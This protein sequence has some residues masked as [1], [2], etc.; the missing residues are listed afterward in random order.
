MRL[1]K[2]QNFALA[3]DVLVAKLFNYICGSGGFVELTV[4][5]KP[6]SPLGSRK[7]KLEAKE[8]LKTQGPEVGFVCVKDQNDE[9]IGVRVDLRKKICHQYA[10][11]GSCR[12]AQGKCKYWHICQSFI[13]GICDGKCGLSHDF[14]S[15]D[16][17]RMVKELGLEKYSNGT[18]RNIVAWSLPQVCQLYLRNECKS[19]KCPYLHVCLQVVQGSSCK[20]ILSHNLSDSHNIKILKQYDLVPPHQIIN[21]DFVR[22][23]ILVLNDQK[24]IETR[25]CLGGGRAVTQETAS[26]MVNGKQGAS[27]LGNTQTPAVP[28]KPVSK[29]EPPVTLSSVASSAKKRDNNDQKAKDLFECLCKEFNCSAPLAVLKN[30]KYVNDLQDASLFL[31][32]NSGKFLFTRNENGNIKDVTAFCPKLRLCFDFVFLSECKK[33]HCSSFHL[34]RKFV[35]GSCSRGEK[36]SR[37]HKFR[38]KRDQETVKKLDLDWLTNE[39]LRKLMLSSSPQVCISYNKDKCTNDS[40]CPRVHICKDFVVNACKNGDACRFQHK[41]AFDTHHTK[42]LLEKYRLGK[43]SHNSVLKTILVCEEDSGPK[44]PKPASI[45][46]LPAKNNTSKELTASRNMAS[47]QRRSMVQERRPSVSSSRSSEQAYEKL[48]PSK[49]AVFACISKEYNGS[50]PFAVISK[51]KDLFAEDSE[52]I[53]MWFRNKKE[54]FRLVEMADGTILEVNAFCRRAGFCYNYTSFT[55]CSRKDCEY[56]HVCREYIA[57]VCKFG[58]RCKWNHSFQFDRDRKFLCKL[59]LDDL[60]EEE[61]CKVIQLSTPQVCLN[62]NDGECKYDE[63][64]SLVHI[65]KD[66]LKKRCQDTKDCGLKHEEALLTPHTSAI[67]RNYGLNCTDGNLHFVLNTLLICKE[68]DNVL[69]PTTL[70][71]NVITAPAQDSPKQ[72]SPGQTKPS[73]PWNK[74]VSSLTSSA[75]V[76]TPCFPTE[77]KVFECLCKGYGSSASFSEIAEREDLFPHGSKSAEGWFRRT[78]GSFLMTE[79]DQGMISQVDAFSARARLCL[80]YNKNGKCDKHDCTY[81]H[82]CRDY[83]TDSCSS[84][85]TCPLNH[86]FHNERDKALLTR[87]KLDQFTDL[88]LRRL[89]LS[90]TPQICVEYNNDTCKRGKSCTKIHICCGYLRKCCSSQYECGLDHETAMDTD[91][92]QKVLE[93]LMLNN[94]SKQD[95]LEMILDDKHSLSGKDKTECHIHQDKPKASICSHFLIGKCNKGKRCLNH[96]CSMPYHWQYKVAIFDEW[97]SFSEK[98]N[99]TL[100]KLYCDVNAETRSK[101]K[102]A[103]SLDVSHLERQGSLPRDQKYE[104]DVDLDN[105]NITFQKPN[106]GGVSFLG[107]LRRLSTVAYVKNPCDYVFTNWKWYW[108]DNGKVWR[109]YDKDYS[110]RGLQELLE[111]A[112]LDMLDRGITRAR[113]K[114]TT[115]E[116]AYNLFFDSTREMYQVNLKFGTKRQVKRRP[117][118]HVS[119]ED[120]DDVKWDYGDCSVRREIEKRTANPC[121]PSHWSSMRPSAQYTRVRLDASSA[122]FKDVG[123]LFRKTMNDQAKIK[124]IERVQNP[125]MWEKYCRKK[126]NM[127]A[128][129]QRNQQQV[130]E[131]RLFHGTSPGTVEAICKQNFDWR[132]HGK[133]ATRFGEGS[134]FAVNASYS[135]AYATRNDV[136]LSQ[137]MFMAKVLVG[138]YTKGQPSYRR[139]PQKDPSNPASDLYDSCVDNQSNPTI[140]VVFDT[141]QFYPEYIIKYVF[142]TNDYSNSSP[143]PKPMPLPTPASSQ[144]HLPRRSSKLHATV[145]NPSRSAVKSG[146]SST[147]SG[148]GLTS[149]NQPRSS[150]NVGTGPNAGGSATGSSTVSQTTPA[151]HVLPPQPINAPLPKPGS[152]QTYPHGVLKHQTSTSNNLGKAS[153]PRASSAQSGYSASAASISGLTS[154]HP[155]RRSLGTASTPSGTTALRSSSN[156]GAGPNAGGSAA[157]SGSSTVSQTTSASHALSQPRTAPLPKPGSSQTYPHG[158]LQH[159]TSTSS[160]LGIASTPRATAAQSG[161]SASAASSSGWTSANPTTSSLGRASNPSVSVARSEYSSNVFRS[162]QSTYNTSGLYTRHDTPITSPYSST[163]SHGLH[164]AVTGTNKNHAK[165]KKKECVIS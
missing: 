135:H 92:T 44:V 119:N 144:T 30:R 139:P 122:E 78:K 137:F 87:I 101:F 79:N 130:N 72:S 28:E 85:V 141:D 89:V 10:V 46:S 75:T 13:E 66:F 83:I 142:Q 7:T 38:N 128:A 26:V 99:L 147:T 73:D 17:Q 58:G 68:T 91:Q 27:S 48:T 55:S 129:A 157:G 161:Y 15:E 154:A 164:T 116:H 24:C 94:V 138:S 145:P 96:H 47:S 131:K 77:Q 60:T 67:L 107:K 50:V 5:L 109:M 35:T 120:M 162:G 42:S 148:L 106:G 52:N 113:Y 140:Y 34:C 134:Y 86:Q 81:L 155:T 156:V 97:K 31:E 115:S 158:I 124:S 43:T 8:W 57:G 56:F 32:E 160:N 59:E 84:G 108:K 82:I 16:N 121:I 41:V 123:Q 159:Q 3:D 37:S 64:C 149:G 88:Q 61:L 40:T 152:S 49:K 12:R 133:N 71:S 36:C 39:Q 114:F 63:N 104:I 126:E 54:S 69:K 25:K 51:R 11:K 65:C 45:S 132:L 2:G 53:A 100:E 110:G 6:K 62:Y 19:D 33:E 1:R 146:N 4:L 14:L 102:P 76:W 95:V 23:S 153:T 118:K 111:Q 150:S 80:G 9:I 18:I 136:D 117:E 151:S 165:K 70:K 90:S 127:M 103:Q 20:C 163:S 21:E 125:F 29:Q 143:Q 74:T 112:F 22:C 93:R 105:M 98:D